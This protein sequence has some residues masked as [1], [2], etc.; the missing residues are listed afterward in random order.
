MKQERRFW[1]LVWSGL[2]ASIGVVSLD[3]P[4][5]YIHK[6][7]FGSSL[8]TFP[9]LTTLNLVSGLLTSLMVFGLCALVLRRFS[10][11]ITI[12]ATVALIVWMEIKW[13]HS[14][15]S[16]ASEL[17]VRFSEEGG[18]LLS[19]MGLISYLLVKRRSQVGK[20]RPSSSE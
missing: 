10:V 16:D 9:E 4:S 19:A 6:V 14:R 8:L 12:A 18:I 1:D 20:E 7:L 17:L 2:I 15:A 5:R 3:Y 13:G 11:R